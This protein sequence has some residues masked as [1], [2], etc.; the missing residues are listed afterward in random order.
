MTPAERVL[1]ERAQRRAIGMQP[2]LSAAIFRA[3]ALVRATL[4]VAALERYVDTGDAD[5]LVRDLFTTELLDRATQPFRTRLRQQIERQVTYFAADVPKGGRVGGQLVVAFDYLNPRVID[6][7]RQL[8]TRVITTLS[9]DVRETVRAFVENGLRDGKGTAAIARQIKGVLGLAPSQAEAVRNFERA[10]RGEGK[11]PLGYK[12]RDKRYD[13]TIKKGALTEQQITTQVA[14]YQRKMEAFHANTVAR[15]AALD[16]TKL[17]QRLAWEDAAERGLVDR[18]RLQKTWVGVKDDRER[19]EHL[20]ME[21]ET[22]PFDEPFSNGQMIP[23][24]DE[25]NCRCVARYSQAR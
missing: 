10:L 3:F 2:A 1:W 25:Y 16:A 5:A 9:G 11:N 23:G 19:V 8:E 15:T 6:A 17:G 13:G 22:A 12:L 21:G 7:V 18:R 4:T 24:D 14:A 20:A